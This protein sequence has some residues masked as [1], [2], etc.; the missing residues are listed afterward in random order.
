VHYLRAS[1]RYGIAVGLNDL[2]TKMNASRR[3][4][5]S[6]ISTRSWT[7]CSGAEDSGVRYGRGVGATCH[8]D[9]DSLCAAAVAGRGEW[10]AGSEATDGVTDVEGFT[11]GSVDLSMSGHSCAVSP[12]GRR[13]NRVLAGETHRANGKA[14]ARRRLRS[15]R[16]ASRAMLLWAA[17][18][19]TRPDSRTST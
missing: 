7:R 1:D 19:C 4:G 16:R 15:I 14:G 17:Q 6:C 10:D 13:L 5:R 2:R 18:S 12:A 8:G 9:A 3:C 11:G